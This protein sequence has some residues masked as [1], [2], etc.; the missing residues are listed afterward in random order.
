MA[1]KEAI[2]DDVTP[3][4]S[5]KVV[6]IDVDSI[7][8]VHIE[9][10]EAFTEIRRVDAENDCYKKIVLQ[11]DKIVGAIVVGD[12]GLAKELNDRIKEAASIT[13]DEAEA[14]LS[15]A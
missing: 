5:L 10:E 15:P 12:S 4:T 8:E 3:S 1:G 6:G 9:G 11:D 14:L 7:G 13:S 2:Y